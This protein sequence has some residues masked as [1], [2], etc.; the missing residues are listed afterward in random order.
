MQRLTQYSLLI[1]KLLKYTPTDSSA[2]QIEYT[3]LKQASKQV[4]EL[5][6]SI[7]NEVGKKDDLEKLD[8]LDEHVNVKAMG[9]KFH[10]STN[11]MGPRKLVYYGPIVK[12]S[13]GKE[14]FAFLFNDLVLI[15]EASDS[16]QNEI[17]R[18]RTSP[19]FQQLQ[20]YKQVKKKRTT[21]K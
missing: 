19:K 17:F 12:E 10:S 9:L 15:V 8:W 16:L 7:N 2:A 3:N 6:K 14:L 1:D 20:V 5:I 4:I 13:G 18:P 11:L 21:K